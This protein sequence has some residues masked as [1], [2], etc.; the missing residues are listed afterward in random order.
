M[1]IMF[2]SLVRNGCVSG[3]AAEHGGRKRL[4]FREAEALMLERG[5]T[6]IQVSV[7]RIEQ[8]LAFQQFAT[9]LERRCLFRAC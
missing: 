9:A 1:E 3:A 6:M 4:E 8:E 5:L 7:A 2:C